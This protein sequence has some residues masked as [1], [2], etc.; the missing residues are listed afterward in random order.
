MSEEWRQ[1][2]GKKHRNCYCL[3]GSKTEEVV[4]SS[5]GRKVFKG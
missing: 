1:L 3:P 4:K 5:D 2:R